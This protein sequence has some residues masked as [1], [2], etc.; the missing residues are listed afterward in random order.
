MK[1]NSSNE[2]TSKLIQPTHGVTIRADGAFQTR[3]SCV[4]YLSHRTRVDID[5]IYGVHQI[6]GS[7]VH[8]LSSTDTSQ[9]I[10][11]LDADGL[12]LQ[13]KH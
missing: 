2:V 5:R 8:V 13:K 12:V 10:Y 11:S 3:E 9:S 4:N 7:T 6:H 1:H